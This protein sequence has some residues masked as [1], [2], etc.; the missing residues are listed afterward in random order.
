MLN[1]VMV[2]KMSSEWKS[3]NES[4]KLNMS[5]QP[6]KIEKDMRKK[7][8]H[9]TTEKPIYNEIIKLL[10]SQLR[11]IMIILNILL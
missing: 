6:K 8:Q 4:E 1:K 7:K 5:N 3:M 9:M 11:T 10:T 2:S